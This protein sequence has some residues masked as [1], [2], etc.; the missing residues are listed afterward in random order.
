MRNLL[1]KLLR[2][3]SNAVRLG[4][5]ESIIL[6]VVADRA[7]N[8]INAMTVSYTHLIS[9]GYCSDGRPLSNGGV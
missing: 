2:R 6:N 9:S 5:G 7:L 3:Q 4:Q 8:A 1:L